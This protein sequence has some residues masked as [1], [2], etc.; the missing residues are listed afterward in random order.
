[1]T[2]TDPPAVDRPRS[3][4]VSLLPR[5]PGALWKDAVRDM[6]N[7]MDQEPSG[8][9]LFK[10]SRTVVVRATGP[11]DEAAA[12]MLRRIL[13][14]LIDDHGVGDLVVDLSKS[15]HLHD[16]VGSVLD[17]A[18]Q[19]VTAMSGLMELRLPADTTDE[20]VELSGDIP[21]FVPM[22]PSG[23]AE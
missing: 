9:T 19:R 11:V 21:T 12:G 2:V 1:M 14:D 4:V 13:L 6:I 22:D 7:E 20:L 8:E 5:K 18:Q 17:E 3:H 15:S 10:V 23:L 16:A